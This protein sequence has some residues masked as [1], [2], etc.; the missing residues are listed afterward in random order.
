M[1]MQR[2]GHADNSRSVFALPDECAVL[3]SRAEIDVDAFDLVAFKDEDLGIP[4]MPS[5][6]GQAFVG[7]KGL[8]AVDKN[9]F[10]FMSLD[11][12]AVAPAPREIRRVVDRV[13]IRA[14]E[15]EIISERVFHGL[16]VVIDIGGKD[17]AD[18]LGSVATWHRASSVKWPARSAGSRCRSTAALNR[19]AS[20]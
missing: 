8:I 5:V 7:H 2:E 18:D 17:G 4:E 10:D 16:T 15:A 1:E 12:V 9:S 11:P 6:F 13:V 14:G 3:V 19:G 20:T